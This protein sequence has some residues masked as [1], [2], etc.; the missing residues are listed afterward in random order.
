MNI[1]EYLGPLL[2]LACG[3]YCAIKAQQNKNNKINP[4]LYGFYIM[5]SVVFFVAAIGVFR[6]FYKM[7]R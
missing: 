3:I 6:M 4:K 5:F 7:E 2:F 1:G